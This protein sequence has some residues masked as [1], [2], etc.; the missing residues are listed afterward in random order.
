MSGH[1]FL[2]CGDITDLTCDSLLVPCDASL[3]I[4][5]VFHPLLQYGSPNPTKTRVHPYHPGSDTSAAIFIADVDKE[6]TTPDKWYLRGLQAYLT[7]AQA[8][9]T[10]SKRSPRSRRKLPLF[11]VPLIGKIEHGEVF[12]KGSL[13]TLLVK[14]LLHFVAITPIDIVFVL[15]TQATFDASQMARRTHLLGFDG[16]RTI[17]DTDRVRNLLRA[18][19]IPEKNLAD[20]NFVNDLLRMGRA[21]RSG[22]LCMF[23]GAGL[24]IPSGLPSWWWLLVGL[25]KRVG[26]TEA[27]IEIIDELPAIDQATV[28]GRKFEAAR[29]KARKEGNPEEEWGETLSEA[30][31]SIIGGGPQKPA[32]GHALVASM[33]ARCAITTNYDQLLERAAKAAEDPFVILPHE[34]KELMH[35]KDKRWLLK[36]HGCVSRPKDIVLTRDDY[37]RYSN[38]RSALLGIVSAVLV[39][40]DMML[41]GFSLTDDNFHLIMG[42]LMSVLGSESKDGRNIPMATAMML[43][44]SE[45]KKQLWHSDVDF[46]V[47]PGEVPADNP[48]DISEKARYHDICLDVINMLASS[49]GKKYFFRKAFTAVLSEDDRMFRNRLIRVLDEYEHANS[50]AYEGF[51]RFCAGMGANE[52]D[53][54][55]DD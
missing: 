14:A 7:A 44:V 15:P 37:R 21:A 49:V 18:V 53:V 45:A 41:V 13:L 48:R 29:D 2:I 34:S 47:A 33:N 23:V 46:I 52:R 1:L 12:P 54:N 10:K 50:S 55:A 11:A 8:A 39:T 3:N 6:S 17:D 31:A 20:D 36:M 38:S 35:D 25:G 51:K 9:F 4:E 5:P 42:E 24:S 19:N 43:S 27:D 16:S 26:M 40:K 30:V 28:I 32:L 22:D